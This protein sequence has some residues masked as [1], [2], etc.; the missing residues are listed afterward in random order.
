[1]YNLKR[2]KAESCTILKSTPTAR[3]CISHGPLCND[4]QAVSTLS[5]R[6]LSDLAG[7]GGPLLSWVPLLLLGADT[8][9]M[10]TVIGWYLAFIAPVRH[11][12]L[13]F[14]S[15][16]DPSGHVFV[17]GAQLVPLAWLPH[18]SRVLGLWSAV[19]VVLSGTTG[20]FF[21]SPAETATGWVLVALLYALLHARVQVRALPVACAWYLGTGALVATSRLVPMRIAEIVYD[22]IL[23]ALLA[24][25]VHGRKQ[26]EGDQKQAKK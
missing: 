17:Y 18:R 20:A 5:P 8:G 16:F 15:G 26:A 22:L 9:V 21:H 1:M 2:S 19:L 14:D 10:A 7:M 3:I 25:L 23:S 13:W 4:A 24:Y 12:K 11:A 6:W